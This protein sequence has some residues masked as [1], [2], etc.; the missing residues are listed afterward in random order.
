[1]GPLG[2]VGVSHA[3]AGR[4]E[5]GEECEVE[6]LAWGAPGAYRRQF[7][8]FPRGAIEPPFIETGTPTQ[9]YNT[10]AADQ[11]ERQ[12]LE[13]CRGG[14]SCNWRGLLTVGGAV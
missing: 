2:V 14:F 11:V 8:R 3:V 12:A 5:I 4:C 7:W 10:H 9:N 6:N 13:S 1:M